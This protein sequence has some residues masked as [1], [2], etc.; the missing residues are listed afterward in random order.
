MSK[1]GLNFSSRQTPAHFHVFFV[2][3]ANYGILAFIFIKILQTNKNW[4]N[5]TLVPLFISGNN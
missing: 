2:S 1:N 4:L 5:A 3:G